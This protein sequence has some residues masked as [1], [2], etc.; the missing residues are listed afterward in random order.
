MQEQLL[1]LLVRLGPSIPHIPHILTRLR[2]LSALHTSANEF[3]GT[4]ESLEEEQRKT[5]NA[6]AE[7]DVA[8]ET[9]ENSLEDN[10]GV[11]KG[12]VRGLEG[13]I[14][15]LLRKLEEVSRSVEC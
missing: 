14:D 3:Q 5:Q 12:N 15:T 4:L 7:L 2:T 11:V 6:L 1:P 8:V 13:R 10:R 9:V